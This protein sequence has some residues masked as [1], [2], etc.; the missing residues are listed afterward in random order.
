MNGQVLKRLWRYAR[1]ARAAF[2]LSSL[3]VSCRYFV[4]NYLTAY[5]TGRVAEAA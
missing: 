3:F 4:I 2:L 5:L 1:P